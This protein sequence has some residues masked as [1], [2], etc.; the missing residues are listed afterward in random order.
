MWRVTD[1]MYLSIQLFLVSKSAYLYRFAST[2]P[3]R[4]IWT[5]QSGHLC[6]LSIKHHVT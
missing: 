4:N 6:L 5:R 1:A 2:V 3:F